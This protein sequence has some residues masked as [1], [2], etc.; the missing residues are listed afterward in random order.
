MVGGIR[1][2]MQTITPFT[3]PAGIAA[4]DVTDASLIWSRPF[5]EKGSAT[6]EEPAH[7]WLQGDFVYAYGTV[8][9]AEL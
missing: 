6:I 8:V 4:Y 9:D 2:E 1:I 7:A 5:G 3:S